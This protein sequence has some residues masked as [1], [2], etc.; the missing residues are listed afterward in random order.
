MLFYFQTKKSNKNELNSKIKG[1]FGQIDN[2]EFDHRNSARRWSILLPQAWMMVSINTVEIVF[3]L[4][5]DE[6]NFRKVKE[7]FVQFFLAVQLN[8]LRVK[9]S[10]VMWGRRTDMDSAWL[11]LSILKK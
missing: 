4:Y 9:I 5:Y 3:S 2:A 11:P 6:S 7:C 1:V 8:H 10:K